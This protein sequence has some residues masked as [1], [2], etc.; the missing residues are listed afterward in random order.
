MRLILPH[1]FGW[2]GGGGGGGGK[3]TLINSV[4]IEVK[5]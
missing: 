5:T 1:W 3:L 4:L 2:E